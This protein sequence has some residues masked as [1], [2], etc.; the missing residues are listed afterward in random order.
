MESVLSVLDLVSTI[1][2]KVLYLLSELL[3]DLWGE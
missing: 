2:D 3:G 1:K